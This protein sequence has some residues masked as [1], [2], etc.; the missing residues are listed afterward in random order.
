[1]GKIVLAG[2]HGA[3]ELKKQITDF[4]KKKNIDITDLGTFGDAAV[5]YPDIALA[6]CREFLK[7]GYDFGILL[8]GTGIGVC[9]TANK[10]K[11]IRCALVS[12]L[13]TA[14]MAKAH[15]NANFIAF[16]GRVAYA[17]PVTAMIEKFM[18]TAYEGGRHERRIAKMMALDKQG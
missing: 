5:D 12:D 8:C 2:D 14:E 11:G 6:A 9:I 1:M 10:V 7:G 16:G 4:L 13:F 15:N 18:T 17:T 3:V